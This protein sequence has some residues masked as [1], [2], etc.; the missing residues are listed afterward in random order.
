[1]CGFADSFIAGS[2]IC[3]DRVCATFVNNLSIKN[4]PTSSA[5]L[6][7]GSVWNNLGVLNIV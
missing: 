3:A 4:I 1:M 2:C 6:P 7:A 5:G